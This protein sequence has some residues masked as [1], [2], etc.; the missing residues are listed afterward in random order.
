MRGKIHRAYSRFGAVC[1]VVGL[2]MFASAATLNGGLSADNGLIPFTIAVAPAFLD[3][4]PPPSGTLLSLVG[5]IDSNVLSIDNL[6]LYTGLNFD[7][8]DVIDG[9]ARGVYGQTS[10]YSLPAISYLSLS[11]GSSYAGARL[12]LAD[13]LR[14]NFGQALLRAG[15]APLLGGGTPP[16]TI[17]GMTLRGAAD[18]VLSGISWDF[19]KWGGISF[20]AAQTTE[21]G[22]LALGNAAA[23][24]RTQLTTMG[25]TAHVGFGSGW[26]TTLSYNQANSQLSLKPVGNL[27]SDGLLHTQSYGIAVAKQGLFGHDAL[28]LSLSRPSGGYNNAIGSDDLQFQF[29][30]RDKLFAGTM[31]ETDINLGYI[32]SFLDGPIALQANASYQM[33]YNGMNKD[34]LS[35]MSRA[36]IK[37]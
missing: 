36:K 1:A 18:T 16:W 27:T 3:P 37:F 12:M 30:G 35:F 11:S 33:N 5:N 31:P 25:M 32:T 24:G 23:V 4:T 34:S 10:A 14:F 9:Y 20:S 2:G 26:V 13:G 21:R 29:Y 17:A 28:G 15:R 8:G 22:G 19:A 6:D 7:V